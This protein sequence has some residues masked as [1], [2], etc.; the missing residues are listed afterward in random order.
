MVGVEL[1][2]MVG[3][4]VVQQKTKHSMKMLELGLEQERT[5][6]PMRKQ[7]ELELGRMTMVPMMRLLA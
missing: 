5:T 7:L 4:G 3:V 6:S 1:E 2:R